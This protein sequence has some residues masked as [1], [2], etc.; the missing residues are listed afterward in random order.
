LEAPDGKRIIAKKFVVHHLGA[1]RVLERGI[2]AVV[3]V[4][5]TSNRERLTSFSKGEALISHL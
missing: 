5:G 2:L 4:G 3:K 1:F